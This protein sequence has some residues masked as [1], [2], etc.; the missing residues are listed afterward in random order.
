[1]LAFPRQDRNKKLSKSDAARL[2]QFTLTVSLCSVVI[3]VIGSLGYGLYIGSEVVI[4]NGI[5]SLF[6]L[7]GSILN[8]T[9]A[10]L[11]ARPVDNKFQYGYWH[12][13]P[14]VLFINGLL[15]CCI[16]FYAIIN[17]IETIRTGGR[18]VDAAEVLRFGVISGA[19]CGVVWIF[20][21][22][23]VR[24]IDSNLVRNDA[25]E[26][27][28]DFISSTITFTGFLALRWLEE[29]WHTLWA[30]Y[31]DSILVIVMASILSPLPL[32]VVV[33]NIREILLITRGDDPVSRLVGEEMN[34]IRTDY[35]GIISYSTH[36]VKVGRSYFVE[37]NILV[38]PEFP[39]Q[40]V[41]KQ[42]YLRKRL[43]E[44]CGK[45]ATELW[46]AVCVTEEERWS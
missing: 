46:L 21:Y 31:A 32:R 42:D 25:R 12:L 39:L 22:I 9:A 10:K 24:R 28:M 14:M 1:M 2:E 35:S 5:F 40:S 20:E 17:S 3:L 41:A 8:L 43:W 26:W 18:V 6:S 38:S 23:I 29:P 19:L 36:A 7:L 11:V 33:S 44:A 27:F 45:E 16:C 37:V 34:R 15:L 4:A 13:E 30:R